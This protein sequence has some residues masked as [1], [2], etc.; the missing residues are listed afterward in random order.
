[1]AY[2]GIGYA[3]AYPE[4]DLDPYLT[5]QAREGIE[6]LR[7]SSVLQAALRGPHFMHASELTQPNVLE[8]PDWKARLREN[9]LGAIAPRRRCSCTTP[10]RTRSSPSI[11]VG[12]CW[13]TGSRW[14]PTCG[15]TSRRGGVDHISGAVAGTPVALEWAVSPPGAPLPPRTSRRRRARPRHS[16]R[17]AA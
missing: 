10:A 7:R 13:R 3:A 11:R 4:L 15:S 12:S 14:A 8:L 16:R 1:M 17:E 2:G 9:R 6:S 5:P